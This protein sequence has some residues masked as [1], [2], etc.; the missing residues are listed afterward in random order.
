VPQKNTDSRACVFFRGVLGQPWKVDV[1][2]FSE[3]MTNRIH[4]REF[5]NY[6]GELS[7]SMGKGVAASEVVKSEAAAILVRASTLTKRANKQDIQSR[8]TIKR[9]TKQSRKTGPI[10]QN[11]NLVPF[12]FMRGKKYSTSNYYPKPVW[13]EMKKKLDF[14][15]KRAKLRV[16]SGK[17]V[18]LI[19]ARKARLNSSRFKSKASLDKAIA[20]QA[21]SFYKNTTEN[22]RQL[23]RFHKFQ[24]H[25]YNNSVACLNKNA[26]G[27]FAIKSAMGG[28]QAYFQTNMKMGVFKSAARI[29]K[30]YPGVRISP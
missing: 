16:F 12:V 27:H 19:M 24:I 5:N 15:K 11:P 29:G 9:S 25:I 2:P 13:D 28:R 14:Y 7:R 1:C 23:H 18:W 8:Y 20:S 6:L 22:G 3:M 30:K 21:T 17:A 10:E 26:R 4:V